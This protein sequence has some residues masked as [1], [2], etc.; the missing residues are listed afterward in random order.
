VPPRGPLLRSASPTSDQARHPTPPSARRFASPV[1]PL[2]RSRIP[3]RSSQCPIPSGWLKEAPRSSNRSREVRKRSRRAAS[4]GTW[5]Q[6]TVGGELGPARTAP[7]LYDGKR[8]DA[9]RQPNLCVFRSSLADIATVSRGPNRDGKCSIGLI[10]RLLRP[11]GG[12]SSG[13]KPSG[14]RVWGAKPGAASP[15]IERPGFHVVPAF[16]SVPFYSRLDVACCRKQE[17]VR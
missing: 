11:G 14:S 6:P 17:L 7:T 5:P 10:S 3:S 15:G 2:D 16:A 4:P 8:P 13:G 12:L 1:R 9:E